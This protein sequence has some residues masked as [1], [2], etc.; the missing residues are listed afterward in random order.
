MSMSEIVMYFFFVWLSQSY[1]SATGSV[2][3]H[4]YAEAYFCWYLID[5]D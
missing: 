1:E 2:D 5:S 3:E 4:K